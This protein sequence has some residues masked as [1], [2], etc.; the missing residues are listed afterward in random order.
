MSIEL[1]YSGPDPALLQRMQRMLMDVRAL[2]RLTKVQAQSVHE[3]LEL[4]R[5]ALSRILDRADGKHA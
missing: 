5:D 3:E 4:V 1:V 2:S